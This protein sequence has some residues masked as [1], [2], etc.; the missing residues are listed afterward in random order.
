MPWE[1][2]RFSAGRMSTERTRFTPAVNGGILSLHQDSEFEF[3]TRVLPA[4]VSTAF[5]SASA[6]TVADTAGTDAG[7]GQSAA[8]ETGLVAALQETVD[9]ETEPAPPSLNRE[10][11]ASASGLDPEAVHPASAHSFSN[12]SFPI[13]ESSLA[14]LWAYI[15]DVVEGSSCRS[16]R[17]A[18][19]AP[20]A[21]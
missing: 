9:A 3:G 13:S 6:A 15:S 21:S 4:E 20:P 19:C 12:A 5:S 2:S 16:A 10:N 7:S 8:T 14:S 18:A 1:S 17:C 11:K